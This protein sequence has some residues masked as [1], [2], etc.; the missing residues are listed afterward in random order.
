ML[1]TYH[2]ETDLSSLLQKS[3]VVPF[4]V[5]YKNSKFYFLRFMLKALCNLLLETYLPPH[6]SIVR[7]GFNLV[8]S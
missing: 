6:K 2:H 8:T 1:L 5:Q 7:M 4:Q 3:S